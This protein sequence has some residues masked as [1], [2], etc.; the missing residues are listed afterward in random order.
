MWLLSIDVVW[1]GNCGGSTCRF[2]RTSAGWSGKLASGKARDYFKTDVEF[3]QLCGD[4]VSEAH[5]E[6]TQ[7]FANEMMKKANEHGLDTYVSFKQ[8]K[9]LCSIADWEVP[10]EL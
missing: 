10:L 5:A 8:L 4:A 9:F 7:T 6:N 2:S 3:R 1:R